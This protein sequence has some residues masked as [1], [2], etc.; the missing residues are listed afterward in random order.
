MPK[1]VS[2]PEP[3]AL[4]EEINE[5]D[6]D[7]EPEETSRRKKGGRSEKK[8]KKNGPPETGRSVWI[9]SCRNKRKYT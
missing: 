8:K 6:Y 5:T 9:G 3:E 7:D 4:E 2:K 1:Q